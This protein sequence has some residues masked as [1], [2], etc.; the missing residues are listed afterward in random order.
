VL[1]YGLKSEQLLRDDEAVWRNGKPSGQRALIGAVETLAREYRVAQ[2]FELYPF[3]DPVYVF[4]RPDKVE[5]STTA[6]MQN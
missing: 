5:T 3:G 4:V 1:I 6:S 2:K